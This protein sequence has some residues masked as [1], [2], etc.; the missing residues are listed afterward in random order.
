MLSENRLWQSPGRSDMVKR[1]LGKVQNWTVK[2]GR[3]VVFFCIGFICLYLFLCSIFSTCVIWYDTE[4]TYYIKDFPVLMVLG[5]M[6]LTGLMV[7]LRRLW[8]KLLLH[9]NGTVVVLT[10]T[11]IVLIVGFVK[12]CS[13]VVGNGVVNCSVCYCIN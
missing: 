11:W 10:V 5:L 13:Y 8:S 7:Y 12:C 1:C 2:A 3:N 4:R 6:G 9:Q